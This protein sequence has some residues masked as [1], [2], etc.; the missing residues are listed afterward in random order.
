MFDHLLRE[1]YPH[2]VRPRP[3]RL[4]LACV[5]A[6]LYFGV[7]LDCIAPLQGG[8]FLGYDYESPAPWRMR[9]TA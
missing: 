5:T 1:L 3:P 7:Q 6:Q 4:G 2:P 9:W 8:G